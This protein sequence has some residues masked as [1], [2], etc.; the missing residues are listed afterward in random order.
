[1][2]DPA[3]EIAEKTAATSEQKPIKKTVR[4]TAKT[5]RKPAARTTQKPA[6]KRARKAAPKA[7]QKSAAKTAQKPA[8][9]TARKSTTKTAQ[10]PV[11]KTARK[12][13]AKT[14][15]AD[16]TAQQSA[17]K[18]SRK[19]AA[20]AA[21]VAVGAVNE[22]SRQAGQASSIPGVPSA[23]ELAVKGTKVVAPGFVASLSTRT[24]SAMSATRAGLVAAAPVVTPIAVIAGA[25]YGVY[26]LVQWLGKR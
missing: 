24:A 16:K 15:T 23:G 21:Q 3:E 13:T 6:T 19:S 9:K 26:K 25:G 12:S 18:T 4:K 1:M 22:L 20:A 11:K 2:S 7:A 10:K 17:K 8:K 14:A 5:A